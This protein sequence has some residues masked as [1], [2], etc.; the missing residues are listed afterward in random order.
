MDLVI[1]RRTMKNLTDYSLEEMNEFAEEYAVDACKG[2]DVVPNV[3]CECGNDEF[4][5]AYLPYQ[6]CGCYVGLQCT[7]CN[8]FN[9]VIDGYA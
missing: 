7:K 3:S 1:R 2:N 5:V 8:S 4:N 6:Y 9:I